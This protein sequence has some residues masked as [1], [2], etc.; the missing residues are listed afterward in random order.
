MRER[1]VAR[2]EV[3]DDTSSL[4]SRAE[5]HQRTVA[6]VLALDEPYRS[7]VLRRFFDDLSP[8][9]VAAREHASEA[10]VR[11]RLKRGLALLR[12]RLEREGRDWREEWVV[13]LT[14]VSWPGTRLVRSGP[15][16]T[17]SWGAVAA[18]VTA[19]AVVFVVGRLFIRD[20]PERD[21]AT[22]AGKLAVAESSSPPIDLPGESFRAGREPEILE[23]ASE[24][25]PLLHGRVT[26]SAG[27]PL[28]EAHVLLTL[29]GF[30]SLPELS[31]A[32]TDADGRFSL[33]LAGWIDLSPYARGL[34][35]LGVEAWA[36]G[37]APHTGP[38]EVGPDDT[39]GDLTLVLQPGRVLSGRVLD[40]AGS[41]V[42]FAI[43]RKSPFTRDDRP[44]AKVGSHWLSNRGSA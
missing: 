28:P 16:P 41:P 27:R 3:Q 8:E 22:S 29:R 38:V 15:R 11:S 19:V 9:E 18:T 12:A 17:A 30:D 37:H 26:D 43:A 31:K 6:A 24:P 4:V 32:R 1:A 42:A 40:S 20:H 36:S 13:A 25:A 2:D 23:T 7:T 44:T 5:I 10:T 34:L 39:P 14:G 21:L 35:E 33:S